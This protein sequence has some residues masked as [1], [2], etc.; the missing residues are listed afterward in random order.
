M[1]RRFLGLASMGCAQDR[2]PAVQTVAVMPRRL[3]AVLALAL[4]AVVAPACRHDGRAL[5]PVKAGQTTTT[6]TAP[7]PTAPTVFT[8]SGP[9][10]DG[11]V[12]PADFTCKGA[13]AS[14]PLTWAAAP[15]AAQ[16]ALVVRDENADGYVHWIVTGISPTLGSFPQGGIPN[17]AADQVNS[18]GAL[19]YQP[20]CPPTG[21]GRH[22]YV[23]TL[24]AL[25]A[26]PQIDPATPAPDVAKMIE[27][28]ASAQAAFTV[29]VAG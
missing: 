10:P 22:L 6:S 14:P 25:P 23:F 3:A 9:V 4:L 18:Q 2:S 17:G 21:S 28:R 7:A 15:A 29:S 24:Y 13:G 8:L 19:G 20:P 26:A 12:L 27:Q 16:L 11:S 5:A 1:A